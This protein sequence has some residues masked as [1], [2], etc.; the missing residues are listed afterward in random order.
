M[1]KQLQEMS[2]TLLD[3]QSGLL[4][5]GIPETWKGKHPLPEDLPLRVNVLW[6]TLI[7]EG[8]VN[9]G[10]SKKAAELFTNMM[11]GIVYGLKDFDG[12]YPLF[13]SKTGQPVGQYNAISGLVPIR[14]FLKIAG[15]KLLSPTKVA[16]WGS[17]PFLWP[18]EINWRG[19]SI[20]KEQEHTRITFPNGADAEHN[21][22]KTVIITVE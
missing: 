5:F 15:V 2:L 17:N 9:N 18:I 8:L 21:S 16:L 20:W 6:N 7:L 3:P 1:E 10:E 11:H 14:L 4:S 19:L 12:F 13:D 22:E